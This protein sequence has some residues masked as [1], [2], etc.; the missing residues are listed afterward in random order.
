MNRQTKKKKKPENKL[1]I[2]YKQLT[3]NKKRG[4]MCSFTFPLFLA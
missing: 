2:K 1:L 4:E 3:P